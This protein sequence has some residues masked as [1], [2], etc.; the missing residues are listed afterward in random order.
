MA[1]YAICECG[2]PLSFKDEAAG[3]RVKCPA[4]GTMLTVPGRAPEAKAPVDPHLESALNLAAATEKAAA[5]APA[6][7]R[8]PIAWGKVGV[9]AGIGVGAAA[10]IVGLIAGV[11]ALV[12]L[13]SAELRKAPV[14]PPPAAVATFS[15]AEP[16]DFPAAE[17]EMAAKFVVCPAAP[18]A[19]PAPAAPEPA[20]EPAIPSEPAAAP[21]PAAPG[22]AAPAAPPEAVA[23]PPP[24]GPA[25]A[26]AE[27]NVPPDVSSAPSAAAPAQTPAPPAPAI[28][29]A[30]PKEQQ[31]LALLGTDFAANIST[32]RQKT[33]AKMSEARWKSLSDAMDVAAATLKDAGLAAGLKS[34]TATLARYRERAC[35]IT[36]FGGR[37]PDMEAVRAIM[38]REDRIEQ[39]GFFWEGKI[40]DRVEKSSP[41]ILWYHYG[42]LAFGSV[43]GKAVIVRADSQKLAPAAK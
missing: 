15:E 1:I 43:N 31:A 18:E 27:P 3:R 21:G 12:N 38:G 25:A 33:D 17:P 23:A 20:A 19:P 16:A 5:A 40:I 6:P 34:A 8:P 2:K 7:K 13:L 30:L 11:S 36:A 26:P 22:P 14:A 28:N 37:T 32:V 24:A 9:A 35:V 39:K 29:P 42:W 10:A 41:P 4:C